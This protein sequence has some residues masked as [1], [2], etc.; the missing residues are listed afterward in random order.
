LGLPSAPT[1]SIKRFISVLNGVLLDSTYNCYEVRTGLA[2][3]LPNDESESTFGAPDARKLADLTH[4]DRKGLEG[5]EMFRSSVDTNE[6][7][8]GGLCMKIDIRG[9]SE[10]GEMGFL[11]SNPWP[12]CQLILS[13]TSTNHG[14][15][16]C[17]TSS[18][19]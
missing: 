11:S 7:D 12:L 17:R 4:V 18:S 1:Y 6:I 19:P 3:R 13:K 15:I 8:R 14:T 16:A 10:Q 9:I 2:P 5:G